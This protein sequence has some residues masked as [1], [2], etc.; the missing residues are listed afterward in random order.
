MGTGDLNSLF[1]FCCWILFSM[2]KTNLQIWSANILIRVIVLG[3]SISFS[4]IQ[5][6]L[7]RFC[8]FVLS[9]NLMPVQLL[10]TLSLV[11]FHH[12]IFTLIKSNTVDTPLILCL[13][14]F[15]ESHSVYKILVILK[16]MK[17]QWKSLRVWVFLIYCLENTCHPGFF[18]CE[19]K[20]LNANIILDWIEFGELT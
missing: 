16:I 14:L 5:H 8:L 17:Y 7:L 9:Q 13:E 20:S 11:W 10:Y 4:K 6:F 12:Q 18:F 3:F 15:R 1:L 2:S 19:A